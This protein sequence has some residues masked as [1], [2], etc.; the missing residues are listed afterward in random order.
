[1][2]TPHV[3]WLVNIVQFSSITAVAETQFALPR[4][5]RKKRKNL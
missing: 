2:L 5:E 1:M 4:V 3:Y